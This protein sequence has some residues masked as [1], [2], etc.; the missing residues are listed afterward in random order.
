MALEADP[1]GQVGNV[2]LGQRLAVLKEQHRQ[3]WD[4]ISADSRS[5]EASASRSSI[6]ERYGIWFIARNA[7]MSKAS[8]DQ[9]WATPESR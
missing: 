3:I 7:L 2:G 4:T 1:F 6:T 9:G 8:F 5:E